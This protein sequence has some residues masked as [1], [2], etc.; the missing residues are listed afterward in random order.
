MLINGDSIEKKSFYSIKDESTQT[1]I[2]SLN[3]IIETEE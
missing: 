3:R 2:T 1:I